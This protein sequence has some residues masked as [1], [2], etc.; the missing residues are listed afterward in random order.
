MKTELNLWRLEKG[1]GEI[2]SQTIR[3]KEYFRRIIK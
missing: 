2:F 1:E 3:I